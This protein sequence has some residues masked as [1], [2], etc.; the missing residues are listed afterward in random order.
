MG[1]ENVRT[2]GFTE[3]QPRQKPRLAGGL[4]SAEG[5]PYTL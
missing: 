3:Y 4:E 2:D 1:S 5:K